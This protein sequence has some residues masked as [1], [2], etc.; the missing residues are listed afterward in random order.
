MSIE[1]LILSGDI[2]S[3]GGIQTYCRHLFGALEAGFKDNSFIAVTLNDTSRTGFKKWAN[4]KIFFCGQVS[5]GFIRRIFFV[6]KVLVSV[7]VYRPKFLIC[8]HVHIAPLALLINRLLGTRYAVMIYGS[9]VWDLK[10]GMRFRALRKSAIIVS[11]SDYTKARMVDNGICQDKIMVVRPA[12]DT[13]IFRPL[14]PNKELLRRLN[15][16]GKRVLLIVSRMDSR[17]RLKGHDIL[18]K[19]MQRLSGDFILVIF[20]NGDDMP[21]LRHMA[22][23]LGVADKVRFHESVS[24][25][26]TLDFYNLCDAFVMPSLQEG[27]GIVFLEALACGKPVIAGSKDASKEALLD[28]KLGFLVN[29]DDPGEIIKAIQLACTAREQ[30]TSPEYLIKEVEANFGVSVFNKRFKDLF[31]GYL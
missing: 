5:P 13:S 8:C 17:E 20:G 29:P 27:F 11:L 4:I 30:R 1:S 19:A 3:S 7:F 28:G 10:N 12:V 9:D 26:D 25:M 22:I 15:L 2:F 31:E 21:R 14:P 18:L 24:V 6:F 23:E 16:E